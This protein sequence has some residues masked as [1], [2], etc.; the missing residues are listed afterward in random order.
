MKGGVQGVWY[1][2][3]T[4][5]LFTSAEAQLSLFAESFNS[6]VRKNFL[7]GCVRRGAGCLDMP[8]HLSMEAFKDKLDKN[9]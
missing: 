4:Q 1:K 6:D 8:Q 9:G 5:L 2:G 3:G 7:F